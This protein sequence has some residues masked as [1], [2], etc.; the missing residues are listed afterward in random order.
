VVRLATFNELNRIRVAFR[1][2][3]NASLLTLAVDAL[4]PGGKIV[5]MNLFAVDLLA[6]LAG[7][8]TITSS[9]L[10]LLIFFP[11]SFAKEAGYKAK[12][13]SIKSGAQTTVQD[14]NNSPTSSTWGGTYNQELDQPGLG[15]SP[16]GRNV[17]PELA[18][19]QQQQYRVLHSQAMPP[20]SLAP[21]H[22]GVGS[23]PPPWELG[24]RSAG[25]VEAGYHDPN[26][27]IMMESRPYIGEDKVSSPT[28]K[29]GIPKR[30]QRPATNILNPLIL[31]YTSP[32]DMI[33]GYA[34]APRPRPSP[35][36]F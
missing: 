22:G 28:V 2:I 12:T 35:T 7:L 10:T 3:F 36:H 19:P 29:L 8:G 9:V 21:G 14:Y 18:S 11:R 24:V 25:D 17:Q 27:Y 30:P 6:M 13:I 1:F 31:S 26:S 32:L 34:A 15:P 33:D 20:R 4:L 23:G 16:Y 5:N